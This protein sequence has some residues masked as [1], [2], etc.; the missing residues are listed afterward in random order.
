M[1][2]EVVEY[3]V[4]QYAPY[5]PPRPCPVPHTS[6]EGEQVPSFVLI[7]VGHGKQRPGDDPSQCLRLQLLRTVTITIIAVAVAVIIIVPSDSVRLHVCVRVGDVEI[8]QDRMSSAR[9]CRH[10]ANQGQ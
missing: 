10:T 2:S 1:R 4:H 5:F 6:R 3:S 7:L 8:F 9:Q